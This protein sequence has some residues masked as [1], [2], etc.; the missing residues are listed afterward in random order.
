[1][2]KIRFAC[3]ECGH[4]ITVDEAHAGKKGKC[5]K[6]KTVVTVPAVPQMQ[7]AKNP[8]KIVSPNTESEAVAE[9]S[10]KREN[11]SPTPSTNFTYPASPVEVDNAY[12]VGQ[13]STLDDEKGKE[14]RFP[15][16]L[17]IFLYPASEAGL[18]NLGIYA[19][20]PIVIMLINLFV[21]ISF[22]RVGIGL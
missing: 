7:L 12:Q 10:L 21:F 17:D 15:W 18:I 14:R 22:V 4:K 5:P 19:V 9:L 3:Q 1:M 8:Q 16:F 11:T 6:C 2:A 13:N 20:L